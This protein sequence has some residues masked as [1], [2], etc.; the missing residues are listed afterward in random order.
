MPGPVRRI[1]VLGD[2]L[3]DPSVGGGAYLAPVREACGSHVEVRNFAKGGFMVN[4]M[5]RRFERELLPHLR[6]YS[7]L[8]VFGGVNDLYSDE[9]AGR[10]LTKIQADLAYIYKAAKVHNVRVIALTVAPW[11]GFSRYFNERRA[12]TTE[13]LN[14]WIRAQAE[15]GLV[16]RAIDTYALLACN[17]TPVLC[18]EDAKPFKDGLHFGRAGHRKVG[19]ALLSAAFSECLPPAPSDGSNGSR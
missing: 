15:Q 10:S 11:G 3:S 4:Q 16:D 19:A 8:I 13:R 6:E 1:A 12:L 9:T 14:A 5:R 17:G 7:D 18:P 2:S